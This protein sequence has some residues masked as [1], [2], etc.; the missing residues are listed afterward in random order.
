MSVNG[1]ENLA[2]QFAWQVGMELWS[3]RRARVSFRLL[4]TFHSS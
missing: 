3:A 4:L 1:E 2:K